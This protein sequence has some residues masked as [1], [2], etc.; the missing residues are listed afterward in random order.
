MILKSN[1]SICQ[2]Y[3]LRY[4]VEF[5]IFFG[6]TLHII[7]DFHYDSLRNLRL[8]GAL[9]RLEFYLLVHVTR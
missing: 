5:C 7:F 9:E 3:T 1:K 8:L 4:V 6:V 2:I